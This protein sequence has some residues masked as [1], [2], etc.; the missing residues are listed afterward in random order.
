MTKIHVV[1]TRKQ[2]CFLW[3]WHSTDSCFKKIYILMLL[4][5]KKKIKKNNPNPTKPLL[6]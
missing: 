6:N 5:G 4:W 2:T 1:C 3:T